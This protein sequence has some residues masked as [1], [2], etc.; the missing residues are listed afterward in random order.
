MIPDNKFHMRVLRNI[1]SEAGAE[2]RSKA[3]QFGPVE[4]A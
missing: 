1:E 4:R 3:L 2:A